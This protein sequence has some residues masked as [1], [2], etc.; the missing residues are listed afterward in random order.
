LHFAYLWRIEGFVVG[1][2]LEIVLS[3]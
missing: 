1:S 3:N 2:M